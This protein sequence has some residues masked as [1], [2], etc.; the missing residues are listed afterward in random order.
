MRTIDKLLLE[1][2]VIVGIVAFATS[3]NA[4]P[5]APQSAAAPRITPA[6]ASATKA[7]AADAAQAFANIVCSNPQLMHQVGQIDAQAARLHARLKPAGR[8]AL[9]A[10]Q[11]GFVQVAYNCPSDSSAHQLACI[12]DAIAQRDRDLRNLDDNLGRKLA[13]CKPADVTIQPGRNGDAGMSQAFN[14]YLLQYRGAGSCR[15]HGFPAIAIQDGKGKGQPKLAKYSGST[16]FSNLKGA[17]L[18]IVLSKQDPSAWFGVHT[19]SACDSSAPGETVRMGLP[20]SRKWL[21]TA[22]YANA[23]CD[24]TVTPIS[25]LSMLQATVP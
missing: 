7:Q 2:R 9:D 5:A 10:Q 3:C 14:T 19:A 11:A 25:M 13:E 18:P 15:I 8:E 21:Y 17:P 6:C 16:Y 22:R 4:V 20:K 1:L 24:V 23:T 12:S